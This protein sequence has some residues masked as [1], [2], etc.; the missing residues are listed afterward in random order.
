MS[1]KP[2]TPNT[3]LPN[4]RKSRASFLD[5]FVSQAEID[6][7]RKDLQLRQD[8]KR[9][10][11][12]AAAATSTP[13]PAPAT[14]AGPAPKASKPDE[15]TKPA[16]DAKPAE[17]AA[18]TSWTP[19]EDVALLSL[20]GQNKTWK[21]IGEILVGKDKDE[22]RNRY[23]EI[24][25]ASGGEG[26]EPAKDGA[27][28]SAQPNAGK[29]NK[30]KQ[31]GEGE[32]KGKGKQEE[33]KADEKKDDAAVVATAAAAAPATSNEAVV[34]DK[35]DS[36]IRG[37]LRQGSDGAFQFRE[38][39]IPDGATTLN[40]CPI[41]YL[42]ENDPL[43]IDELSFLYN[44]NCAFEEQR[45]IRMASKFFDQTGKRIEP[46]WLKDKLKN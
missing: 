22:L 34:A 16:D 18:K 4:K 13:A 5:L 45:W 21:E 38:A 42:E 1:T 35:K 15:A 11:S 2:D 33:A 24:G 26:G 41:I 37:I 6:R 3:F 14:T 29:G 8:R 30:G 9:A 17:G 31:K 23:K 25:G 43:D 10:A 40:G 32:Q 46:E 27:A 20:K 39:T 28:A 7:L 19:A 44:M 12:A 36:K